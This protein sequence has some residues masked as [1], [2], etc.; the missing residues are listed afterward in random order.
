ML[1]N[2]EIPGKI[3]GTPQRL[4]LKKSRAVICVRARSVLARA[5]PK[6][7]GL[8][9]FDFHGPQEQRTAIAGFVL[10]QGNNW[11]DSS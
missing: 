4:F 6:A 3:S 9:E 10:S 2:G 8:R 11:C 7:A 5:T 1:A